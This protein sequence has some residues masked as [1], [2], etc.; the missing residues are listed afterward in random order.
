MRQFFLALQFLTIL[1][2]K[3]GGTVTEKDMSWSV[4]FFPVAGAIQG[5]FAV[6][7]AL[8]SVNFLS[9]EMASGLVLLTFIVINGGF[10]LDGLADTF[11][12]LAVKSGGDPA[13]DRQRKLDI[14]K[15]SSTGAIGVVAIV[16]T[17]LLKFLFLNNLLSFSLS[18]GRYVFLFFMPIFS[19]WVMVATMYY[20]NSARQDGLGKIFIDN[21]TPSKVFLTSLFVVFFY[22]GA[23]IF[24]LHK[25]YGTGSILFFFVISAASYLFCLLSA[26]FFVERFGGLTGDTLGAIGEISEI[27][28]LMVVSIWLQH[29]I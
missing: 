7:M 13:A 14:M 3:V 25:T 8:L 6:G 15:D 10:H 4:I 11:D 12:A 17:I 18:A 28:F 5:L 2:V 21:I 26:R 9:S 27:L 29:S 23:E 16:M 20:G 19:K 1:P 22:A 24:Y